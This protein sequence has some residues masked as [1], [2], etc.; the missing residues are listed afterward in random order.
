MDEFLARLIVRAATVDELL[1]GDFDTL[2]GQNADSDQAARRLAAWCRSSAG[3]DLPLF[4]RRLARDRLRFADVLARFAFARHVAASPPPYIDDAAWIMKALHSPAQHAPCGSRSGQ[5]EAYTFEALFSPLVEEA[6]ARLWSGIDAGQAGN[7]LETARADLRRAILRALSELC[8]PALYHRFAGMRRSRGTRSAARDDSASLYDQF[9]AEMKA[10][11]LRRLFEDKPVPLRLVA[12][13]VRQWIDSCRELVLRLGVDLQAIRTELRVAQADSRVVAIEGELSD[14]HNGGRSVHVL[15]FADGSRV[16]YK[17]KDLR[18]DAAWHALVAR[19]N[20]AGA[21]VAL[22][23]ARAVVRDGYGWAEFVD[24]AGCRD[25]PGFVRFFE[26]AGAWL[27]LFHCFCTTDMHQENLIAAGE[28][29]VPVDLEMTLQGVFEEYRSREPASE[30]AEAAIEAVANS[31]MSVGLLPTHG[32]TP[33]N[34]LFAMGGMGADESSAAGLIWTDVNSDAMRPARTR[35]M[36]QQLPNLPHIEGRYARFDRHVDD[37]VRGFERYAAFLSRRRG[38]AGELSAGFAGLPV[39]RVI[40]PTRF[41]HLL[42]QRLRDQR[43]MDDGV[44]WSAQ[45][46]FMARL[47]DWDDE[48]DFLWPLHAAERNAAVQLNVPHFVARSDG[49]EIRDAAGISIPTAS[50]PG[51]DRARDR[52][53]GFDEREIAWQVE[54]IRHAAG[55]SQP[56]G[57]A[58]ANEPKRPLAAASAAPA[59]EAFLAEADRIAEEIGDRA[60]RRGPGAAWIGLDWLGD[61]EVAQLVPLG[62][63]LYN[64]ASGIAVF[65]AA[66]AALTGRESSRQLALMA[67]AH[68]RKGLRSRSSARMARS[69]GVGGGT[70]LGSVVH[71]LALLAEFLGDDDILA[72][73]DVAA[74]LFTDELIAADRSL[75]VIGGCAGAILALLRLHRDSGSRFALDRALQCG[76]HLLAQPRHGA[77]GRRSWI[78]H[79]ADTRPLNGMSHG[80]AGFA[81]ALASLAAV[82]GREEF[83]QAA[84]ECMALEDSTYDGERANW[85]DFRGGGPPAWSCQWCHGAPGIG[86]ARI[87]MTRKAGAASAFGPASSR[88]TTDIVH[89]L[90]GTERGWPGAIDTL[91]CGTLGS[92]EF[93]CEAGAALERG[94]LRERASRQ[95][96][97]VLQ[98][99]SSS[100]DYRWSFGARRFNLGLFRGLAGVGYT[101]LRRVDGSLPNILIWE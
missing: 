81:Y 50:M 30:A 78:G 72:D 16:V 66:H 60:L 23:T 35:Q 73:A 41:Y 67:V 27:A 92:I 19:L 77:E 61:S 91:C 6:A 22:K 31:V 69:L 18:L 86:L 51:L 68:L 11:G 89:A 25:E 79:G 94:E 84:S 95:L 93:L 39:R 21:P 24:H 57:P 54:V 98:T 26:R 1:S 46:D 40:R 49:Q 4:A 32:R 83:A 80:A 101:C 44:I 14:P 59:R 12:T 15:T 52:L 7:L 13:I 100:G 2:A 99:A 56:A 34:E 3:G 87:A 36:R 70:G 85:P 53:R 37:F 9:V 5:S 48:E 75:D 55:A 43:S 65:L 17:P 82:T 76:R 42:L 62:P 96:M 47:S 90:A 97:T 10:G 29:P 64:G 8:A 38:D 45:A 58:A 71:A 74:R 20:Q 63:D 28:H 88:M 33:D